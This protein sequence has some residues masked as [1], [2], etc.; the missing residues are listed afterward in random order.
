[1][2]G[3]EMSGLMSGQSGGSSSGAQS[4]IGHLLDII[5]L[6]S[7]QKAQQQAQQ[8]QAAVAGLPP[9]ATTGTAPIDGILSLVSM[10]NGG[11]GEKPAKAKP[12]ADA[13]AG[14][15]DTKSGGSPLA[16]ILKVISLFA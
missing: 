8:N 12:A 4:G 1:M 2:D 10:M 5:S 14:A 16:G 9:P 7:K 13:S 11:G 3:S 6:F 15:N